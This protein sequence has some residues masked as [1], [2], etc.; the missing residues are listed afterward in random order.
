MR[1]ILLTLSRANARLGP[2]LRK[3]ARSPE[4]HFKVRKWSKGSNF[5]VDQFLTNKRQFI[6]DFS[7]FINTATF[8]NKHN[9]P[10]I[11]TIVHFSN[12]TF[13]VQFPS[14]LHFCF[15]MGL[16]FLRSCLR[17]NFGDC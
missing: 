10:T 14:V 17:I 16:H 2:V 12:C 3:V 8:K 13:F 15:K 4:K 11:W 9:P 7:R 1:E 6:K 5:K